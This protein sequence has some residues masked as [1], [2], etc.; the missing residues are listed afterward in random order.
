MENESV[1]LK[2]GLREREAECVKER[3]QVHVRGGAAEHAREA[4]CKSG[5]ERLSEGEKE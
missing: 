2:V 4:E 3:G 5:R 1:K